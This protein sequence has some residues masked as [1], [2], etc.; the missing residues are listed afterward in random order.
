MNAITDINYLFS[1][2]EFLES[3]ISVLLDSHQ[4]KGI[5]LSR[6]RL[7]KSDDSFKRHRL[8]DRIVKF[9]H[10]KNEKEKQKK[11]ETNQKEIK[12][13]KEIILTPLPN[14]NSPDKG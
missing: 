11:T 4:L 3:A 2:I 6:C 8:R 1:R 14:Q 13:H 9:L 12:K 7:K 5:Y 10:K